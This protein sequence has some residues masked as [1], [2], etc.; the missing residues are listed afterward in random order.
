[1]VNSK[2][3]ETTWVDHLLP[4]VHVM[5]RDQSYDHMHQL[6]YCRKEE[7]FYHVCGEILEEYKEDFLNIKTCWCK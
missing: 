1:M 3:R 5:E 4:K 7:E 6:M 2:R